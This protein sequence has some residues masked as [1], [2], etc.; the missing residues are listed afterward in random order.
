MDLV[1]AHQLGGTHPHLALGY[2]A[3]SILRSGGLGEWGGAK[4]GFW[5]LTQSNYQNVTFVTETL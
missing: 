4:E 3:I 2:L 1:S 5:L